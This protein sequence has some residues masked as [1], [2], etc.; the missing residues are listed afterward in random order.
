[1]SRALFSLT[2]RAGIASARHASP[3]ERHELY[4]QAVALGHGDSPEAVKVRDVID[5]AEAEHRRAIER[6]RAREE[7][8]KRA[9]GAS[10]RG[11]TREGRKRVII[12]LTSDCA[13]NIGYIQGECVEAEE[14]SWQLKT[15]DAAAAWNDNA[16]RVSIGRVVAADD[17]GFTIRDAHGAETYFRR[18]AVVFAGRVLHAVPN[19]PN[20]RLAILAALKLRL[21]RIGDGI[22]HSSARLR[23]ET[24]IYQIEHP[25]AVE[26]WSAWEEPARV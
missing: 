15:W 25:P 5:A 2:D 1:M 21:A 9:D 10:A 19:L 16:D 7:T 26:D 11:R 22:T 24:E 13:E 18:A 17:H 3:K 14:A 20:D 4:S 8:D 23:L 6:A 12:E